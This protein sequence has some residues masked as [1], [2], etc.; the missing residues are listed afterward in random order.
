MKIEVLGC[1]GGQVGS[2]ITQISYLIGDAL[3]I[4]AGSATLL[5]LERQYK[6]N[7]ILI[8]H[9]HLDHI[10]DIGFIADNVLGHREGPI[11]VI[12]SVEVV[13]AIKKHYLNNIIWPD[14]TAIPSRSDPILAFQEIELNQEFQIGEYTITAFKAVHP[15]PAMGFI[16]SDSSGTVVFSNDTGP[17]ELLWEA[18]DGITDLKGLV[19]E[20]SF[21]NSLQQLADLSGHLT[22]AS[23]AEGLSTINQKNLD[24][25]VCHMKPDA[26]ETLQEQLS[27][28]KNRNI[29]MLSRGDVIEI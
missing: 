28:I 25:Y 15:V 6:I 17:N 8:S 5:S 7:D 3:L 12:S 23:L 19:V 1:F 11:N 14:F 22:P 4:D 16:V 18:V 21:P 27:E 10:K 9:S 26:F 13:N 29:K 24:I 2:Q 20:C